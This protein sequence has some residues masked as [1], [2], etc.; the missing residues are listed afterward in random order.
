MTK[1]IRSLDGLRAVAVSLV[2]CYHAVFGQP[3]GGFIGVD[4]F[5]VLSGFLIT[6]V[7]LEEIEA[8]GSIGVRSFYARR[9]RRLAPAAVA[10]VVLA[11]TVVAVAPETE[12][13]SGFIVAA[14]A[15]LT[16]TA[17][18]FAMGTL[19][20]LQP[21]WSLAV[22]E[23]F[24][25]LWP[26]TIVYLRKRGAALRGVGLIG[27]G[28]FAFGVT[29]Q[30]FGG[31]DVYLVA[32]PRFAELMVGCGLGVAIRDR[33]L[34]SVLHRVILSP[35]ASGSALG[36]LVVLAISMDIHSRANFLGVLLIVSAATA[37]V[38]GHCATTQSVV[39]R[40]LEIRPLVWLGSIS[41]GVYV[42]HVPISLLLTS[43]RLGLTD[44]VVVVLRAV[45]T[46][47]IAAVSFTFLEQPIRSR[48]AALRPAPA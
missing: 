15:S 14:V 24:Y 32:V 47:A 13:S 7:L 23:Q 12:G 3:S 29:A 5:F 48:S 44:P 39:T 28:S 11:G 35:V 4:V 41:Y 19:G 30:T 40:L 21:M 42:Y 17:N 8:T 36:L 43:Q 16:A 34:P 33:S 1:R 38:V 9:A 2:F 6:S 26:T 10:A 25:A 18:F 37:V 46:C 20:L 45:V 22:E 31:W 27:A